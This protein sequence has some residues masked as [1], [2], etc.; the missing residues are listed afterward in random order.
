MRH[1]DQRMPFD[2]R[3]NLSRLAD[4]L[5]KKCAD[6]AEVRIDV[7]IAGGELH[8]LR[9]VAT[10]SVVIVASVVCVLA[11]VADNV[12]TVMVMFARWKKRME[13][14]AEQR[15]TGIGCQ[16]EVAQELAMLEPHGAEAMVIECGQFDSVI[17]GRR[18]AEGNG[19]FSPRLCRGFLVKL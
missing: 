15:N 10:T 8:V 11:T 5:I 2:W 16:Q 3:S 14:V 13:A 6:F 4:R 17:L 9:T 1:D 18:C 7:A 19:R 12:K